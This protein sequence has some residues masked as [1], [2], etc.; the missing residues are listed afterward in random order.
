M[1]SVIKLLFLVAFVQSVFPVD[2]GLI[3][4]TDFTPVAP[5][6]STPKLVQ[7][8]PQVVFGNTVYLAVWMNGTDQPGKTSSDIYCA[9]INPITGQTLDPAGI[10]IC[11]ADYKQCYPTVAFDGT[12]FMVV[13]EDFRSDYDYDIYGARVTEGGEVLD[14]D[15]FP[16]SAR[17]GTNEA[18]PAIAYGSGNYIVTW[19][20][21][22]RY[23]VY[24]IMGARVSVAGE[25]L[26]TAGFEIDG[27][28]QTQ[29]E[30]YWPFKDAHGKVSPDGTWAPP[31][32]SAW[33]GGNVISNAIPEVACNGNECIVAYSSVVRNNLQ[34]T[35]VP[36][37][38]YCTINS[39]TGAILRAPQMV[40]PHTNYLQTDYRLIDIFVIPSPSGWCLNFTSKGGGRSTP[41]MFSYIKLDTA[42]NREH[43]VVKDKKFTSGA[44][45]RRSAL[46]YNGS[47]FL[48]ANDFNEVAGASIRNNRNGIVLYMGDLTDTTMISGD[49]G[50]L[51][52]NTNYNTNDWQ[53]GTWSGDLYYWPALAT[54]PDGECIIIYEKNSGFNNWKIGSRILR[55]K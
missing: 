36:Q 9:R 3:T 20:D 18:R 44:E 38:K 5:D 23:P 28:S 54:G 50:I 30:S 2:Y 42:L 49:T 17:R 12:N 27:E 33:W 8:N 35:P 22:R 46:A 19:M 15:G 26:D 25:L 24:I 48:F 6:C 10:R 11:G 45:H 7:R 1:R 37:L 43:Y 32:G 13:W 14:P 53:A 47:H 16:I 40:P 52:E 21:A 41:R 29:I 31:C 55:E 34:Y 39:S 4:G 51:I